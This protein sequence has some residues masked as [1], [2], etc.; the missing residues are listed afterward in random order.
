MMFFSEFFY[1][2]RGD[3]P[4]NGEWMVEDRL[5]IAPMIEKVIGNEKMVVQY[6]LAGF[7]LYGLRSGGVVE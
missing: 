3:R 2:C 5:S 4:G 6:R 7:E 1:L